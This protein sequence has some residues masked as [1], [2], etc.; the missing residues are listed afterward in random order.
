MKSWRALFWMAGCLAVV[1]C[2]SGGEGKVAASG[3]GAAKTP[4][5]A[6]FE[7]FKALAGDWE[8]RSTKG[9]TERIN[10]KPIAKE[11]C[12]M[13]SSFDAHPKE[14]MVTMFYMDGP[15]LMLT[16][17][18]VARNQPRLR[19]TEFGPD[20]R[21]IT[22]TFQ[23]ATNLPS[24]DKGHMDKVVFKFVDDDH[25]TSQWTWYEKG[26]ESWMEEIVHTRIKGA[27]A[28]RSSGDTSR[29]T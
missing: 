22:F 11:S 26:R 12:V 17:Y 1:G 8:G 9:W 4:A 25:F 24:R 21:S 10:Y 29:G 15:R 19:A 13:E 28:D 16:H 3:N 7:R 14:A 5:L 18:C 23:D 6:G 20:G 2:Q 27:R